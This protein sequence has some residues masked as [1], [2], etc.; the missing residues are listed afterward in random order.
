MRISDALSLP[1]SFVLL[2]RLIV[3]VWLTRLILDVRLVGLT[4]GLLF[5]DSAG[6]GWRQALAQEF[7]TAFLRA[8]RNTIAVDLLI[9]R[10]ARHEETFI[11][12]VSYERRTTV[13]MLNAKVNTTPARTGI[14]LW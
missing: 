6:G 4:F 13:S 14:T 11:K 7:V 12:R 8:I 10:S 9:M 2:T 5:F 3:T 1:L